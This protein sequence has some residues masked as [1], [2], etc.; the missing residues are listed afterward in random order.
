MDGDPMDIV[1]PCR[2]GADNQELRYA[3]RAWQK[4]F[5]M[6]HRK[7]FLFGAPP[8]WTNTINR[9]HR[10]GVNFRANT[11]L[12]IR[13]ACEDPAISDPFI[14]AADDIFLM[15]P[16]NAIPH[17][18]RGPIDEI[19]KALAP[20]KDTYAQ[21]MVATKRLLIDQGFSEDNILSYELHMPMII[22][23]SAMMHTLKVHDQSRAPN[24]HKRTLYGNI[25]DYGGEQVSDNKINNKLAIWDK[26]CLFISTSDT[27]FR[28]HPV[29]E[30]IRAQFTE[31]SHYE[32]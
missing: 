4:N 15:R 20:K 17:L 26:N 11:T 24:L 12:S 32:R 22:H 25:F 13:R 30:W 14:W 31:S 7:I 19:I 5:P 28:E 10:Q 18:N 1:I 27:S 9:L 23:K 6:G 8:T 2:T 3:L 21:G 16:I 29:G